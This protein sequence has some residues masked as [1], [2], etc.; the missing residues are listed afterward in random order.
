MYLSSHIKTESY[1][2][3]FPEGFYEDSVKRK[4]VVQKHIFVMFAIVYVIW[5]CSLQ[6]YCYN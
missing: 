2:K 5:L 3:T 1:G 6:K 4:D